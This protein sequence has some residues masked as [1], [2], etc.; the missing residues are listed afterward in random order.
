MLGYETSIGI[1]Y[2]IPIDVNRLRKENPLNPP[3]P[4]GDDERIYFFNAKDPEGR[5]IAFQY[6]SGINGFLPGVII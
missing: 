3:F 2:R 5:S 6:F 1:R 4:K